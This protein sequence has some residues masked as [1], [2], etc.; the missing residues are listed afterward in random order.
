MTGELKLGRDE[1]QDRLRQ[2]DRA[3]ALLH[4]GRSFRLVL[5]GGGRWCFSAAWPDQPPI[6]MPCLSPSNS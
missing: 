3:V 5:V 4:P 1:L 2:F 6:S